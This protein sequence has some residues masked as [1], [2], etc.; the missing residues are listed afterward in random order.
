MKRFRQ[1]AHTQPGRAHRESTC[2]PLGSLL[3]RQENP[4]TGAPL[5]THLRVSAFCV[6][7]ERSSLGCF[8]LASSPGRQQGSKTPGDAW[9]HSQH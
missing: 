8:T 6:W 4:P 5:S 2:H 1:P 9:N 7:G 3:A